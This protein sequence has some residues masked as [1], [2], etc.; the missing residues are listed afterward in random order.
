MANSAPF[1]RLW[2][3]YEDWFDQHENAYLSELLAVRSLVPVSGRGLE[4]GVGT[5]RFAA[6]L[7][8][9]V[10]VDPARAMLR[11]AA[12]RGVTA[13]Q[14]TAEQLPFGPATF[15]H[16]LTVT[17]ICFVDSAAALLAEAHRVLKPAGTLVVGF[18]DRDSP[19]GRQYVQHQAESD[20]YRAATF[21]SSA[22]VGD[23]MVEAGFRIERWAQTLAG[24]VEPMP[25]IEPVRPGRGAGAFVVVAASKPTKLA[26][27]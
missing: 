5:G 6:P 26:T 19:L 13:V 14:G 20:F 3:V 25:A 16:V 12:G 7:G 21:Y 15:D 9:P 8:I 27:A 18:I 23:L 10:G 2:D 17:T 4:V 1:E 22:E 11:V 24:A